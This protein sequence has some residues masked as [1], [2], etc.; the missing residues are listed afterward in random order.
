M[1]MTDSLDV[2]KLLDWLEGKL[3]KDEAEAIAAAIQAD[4]SV[5]M[6]VNW[7][8]SFLD[9]SKSSTL[10]EPPPELSQGIMT[11]FRAFARGRKQSAWLQRLVATLTSDSWQRPS[12]VGVRH[13]GLAVAPRQLVYQAEAADLVLNIRAGS[14]KAVFDLAGQVFPKDEADPTSFTVQLLRWEIEAG[15]TYTDNV[16]KF[17]FT[18]LAAGTYT[19]IVRGDQVEIAIADVELHARHF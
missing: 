5:Q 8:R 14:D 6:N 16:G 15:L 7:L 9:I 12:L 2:S 17:T 1:R 3:S 19:I 18:N 10:T 4:E 11:Y 13:T